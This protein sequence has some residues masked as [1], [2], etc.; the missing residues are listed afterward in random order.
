MSSSGLFFFLRISEFYNEIGEDLDFD[1]Y[2]RPIFYVKLAKL[3]SPLDEAP[4][5]IYSVHHLSYWLVSHDDDG[6]CLKVLAQF[7]GGDH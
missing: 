7:S 5:Y 6:M 4:C 3:Y 2:L 1:Y